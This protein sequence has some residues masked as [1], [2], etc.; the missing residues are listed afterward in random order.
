MIDFTTDIGKIRA[1][2]NDTDEDNP[3]FSDEQLQAYLDMSSGNIIQAAI[4]ALQGLVSKY[5]ATA[6]DSYRVDTIQYEEGKSKASAYLNLLNSLKQSVQDGTNPLLVGV[7]RTFG[8]YQDD[9][10]ENI[11]RMIDG[12]IIPPKTFDNEYEVIRT[13]EQDGPY[14]P[15]R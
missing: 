15:G 9:R 12:E 8:I 5:T 4:F 2:I 6:G 3:E 13:K 11:E 10:K 1:L 7:P 14:Y